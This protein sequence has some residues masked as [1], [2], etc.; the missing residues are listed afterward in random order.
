MAAVLTFAGQ[1]GAQQTAADSAARRD[2]IARDSVMRD[3]VARDSVRRDSLMRD[4]TAR[5]Q[6]TLTTPTTPTTTTTTTTGVTSSQRIPVR[7]DVGTRPD[8]TMMST[9]TVAD[10]TMRDT[11]MRDTTMR[12]TTAAD[13]AAAAVVTTPPVDTTMRDTTMR[14]TTMRDTT[15]RDTATTAVAVTTEPVSDVLVGR[16]M[17]GNGFYIGI[18]G[19]GTVPMGDL[20]DGYDAGFNVTVPIGWQSMTTP[21]G[22]RADLS[23]NRIRG[24]V[25]E[26]DDG[27]VE[28]DD[29]DIWSGTLGLT[30]QWPVGASSTSFY[31]VGGGGAYHFRDFGEINS[32]GTEIT[33][34]SENITKFG[35]NG[36]AGINFAVGAADIF[37][38]A[39][40]VSVFTEND[41]TNFIPI[42]LGVRFF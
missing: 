14:D 6:R 19:G 21:W 31:L 22:V 13:T 15:M 37:V 16:G 36:G 34:E 20:S 27:E 30:A 2:S 35:L 4:S 25:A 38:D 42:T 7:K 23:Y 41:N 11:T 26:F 8:T 10:T 1:L 40:Y 32:S 12:D 29:G 18:G 17:F 28:L 24:A 33:V 39:R 9:G 3:S 5:A